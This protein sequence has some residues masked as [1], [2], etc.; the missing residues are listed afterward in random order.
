[1]AHLTVILNCP[2]L[3]SCFLLKRSLMT[4]APLNI[5]PRYIDLA[6]FPTAKGTHGSMFYNQNIFLSFLLTQQKQNHRICLLLFSHVVAIHI[7][8]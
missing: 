8:G 4:G 5:L 6:L 2:H 3:V 7:V 1:M